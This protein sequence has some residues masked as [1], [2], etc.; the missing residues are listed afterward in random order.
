MPDDYGA[1]NLRRNLSTGALLLFLEI[2]FPA[3]SA[4]IPSV[5]HELR[6][7]LYECGL[8]EIAEDV[9]LATHELL[10][11]A[12]V[13]GFRSCASD[14]EV[15]VTATCTGNQ[16]RVAVRDL[17]EERPQLQSESQTEEGGRGLRIVAAIADRWGVE[18]NPSGA[19]K[20]VWMEL[21]SGLASHRSHPSVPGHIARTLGGLG[22]GCS[23]GLVA[24]NSSCPDPEPGRS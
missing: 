20:S 4:A 17:S 12:V 2:S 21:D 22:S 1:G 24:D 11:N 3:D 18:A 15:T 7:H 13:H 8:E 14:H 6:V 5:R 10:A 19:G 16:L 9:V 23:A